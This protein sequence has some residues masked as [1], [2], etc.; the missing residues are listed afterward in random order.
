MRLASAWD[1]VVHILGLDEICNDTIIDL[2]RNKTDL[3]FYEYYLLTVV[4]RYKISAYHCKGRGCIEHDSHVLSTSFRSRP[5]R[6]LLYIV[7]LQDKGRESKTYV[8]NAHRFAHVSLG[9][10]T[11]KGCGVIYS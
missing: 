5:T 10:I 2:L 7:P 8:A 4:A 11:R 1:E 6:R 9:N 3:L